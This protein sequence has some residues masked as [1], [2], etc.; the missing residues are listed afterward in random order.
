MKIRRLGFIETYCKIAHDCNG[1][2]NLITVAKFHCEHKLTPDVI[3]K[4]GKLLFDQYAILQSA[5]T[6]EENTGFFWFILNE[7]S[8]DNQAVIAINDI[9]QKSLTATIEFFLENR[10]TD[11]LLWRMQFILDEHSHSHYVVLSAHHA[12]LDGFSAV[13]FINQLIKNIEDINTGESRKII[14]IPTAVEN[15]FAKKTGALKFIFSLLQKKLL[16]FAR[17][18]QVISY[19]LTSVKNATKFVCKTFANDD[20]P[21]WLLI[22]KQNK[23]A[24]TALMHACLIKAI[25]QVISIKEGQRLTSTIPAMPDKN[26]AVTS[27]EIGCL[28]APIEIENTVTEKKS[29]LEI[30]QQTQKS[31]RKNMAVACKFPYQLTVLIQKLIVQDITKPKQAF[32]YCCQISNL[33]VIDELFDMQTKNS[34]QELFFFT[35]R[36]NADVLMSLYLATFNGKL[37]LTFA[38][39]YPLLGKK[40]AEQIVQHFY[41]NLQLFS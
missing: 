30:A 18:S 16:S 27:A 38:Y 34:L 5:I 39:L 9:G 13:K 32:K 14:P 3:Y 19:E 33:G 20:L 24:L 37:Y 1:S 26:T 10:F 4:A 41:A 35:S 23:I 21:N 40:N 8:F 31:I 36:N 2:Y 12:I 7:K 29:V 15:R 28:M 17:N 22:C 11:E 6:K 25:T